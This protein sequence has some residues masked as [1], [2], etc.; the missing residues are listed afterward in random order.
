MA[1]G[2]LHFIKEGG[3]DATGAVGP[4][5]PGQQRV[6][7]AEGHRIR[8]KRGAPHSAC[9]WHAISA[10]YLGRISTVTAIFPARIFKVLCGFFR[11]ELSHIFSV[12]PR[13]PVDTGEVDAAMPRP[14]NDLSAHDA[15][16]ARRRRLFGWL[17]FGVDW[18]FSAISPAKNRRRRPR[19]ETHCAPTLSAG[20]CPFSRRW[21]VLR[22]GALIA[23]AIALAP[24]RT[25]VS[26]GVS[27]WSML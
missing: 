3:R 1:Y 25:V 27:V 6:G 23:S 8:G 10:Y 17:G 9:Y 24:Q 13:G 20:R 21:K 22:R 2:V 16:L 15:T 26:S 11:P 12:L 14:G 5:A 19:V 4:S 18:A 7:Y